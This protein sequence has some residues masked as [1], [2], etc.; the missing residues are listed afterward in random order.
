MASRKKDKCQYPIDRAGLLQE[1]VLSCPDV[2]RKG[3]TMTRKCLLRSK[4]FTLI[5]LLVVIAIIALLL[6]VLIPSLRKARESAK[7]LTCRSNLKQMTLAFSV[8]S[9]ENDG[10]MFSLAYGADYWFRKI[11]PFL[12]DAYF[13]QN[14]TVDYTGV[15][16]V[17]ICPST[18]IQTSKE[19]G[20]YNTTWHYQDGI[21]SYGINCWLLSDVPDSSGKT[22]YEKWGGGIG[23]TTGRYFERYSIARSD[24]GLLAD[25]FRMDVWPMPDQEIQLRLSTSKSELKEPGGLPHNPNYF[26]RR[27]MVDRHGMAVNVGFVGGYVEKVDLVDLG[28]ISWGKRSF[29]RPDLI[30][31]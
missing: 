16:Q 11:A 10:R 24:A 13:Q 20:T 23:Q 4:G 14:P 9:Q 8:Y 19:N 2:F 3:E 7:S 1:E 5:E 29:P 25:A 26:M 30:I 28:L 31:P 12:G 21:G 15:M 6:A 18:K 27:Y 22:W 17:S